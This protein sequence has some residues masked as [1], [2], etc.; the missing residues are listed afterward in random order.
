MTVLTTHKPELDKLLSTPPPWGEARNFE[1]T[2][3]RVKDDE[4]GPGSIGRIGRG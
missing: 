3:A 2:L 1:T 4:D